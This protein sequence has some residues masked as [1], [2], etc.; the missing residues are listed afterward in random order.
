MVEA[1]AVSMA[2]EAAV[3]TAAAEASMVA[4]DRMAVA[5]AGFV[6]AASTAARVLLAE[7]VVTK[8]AGW[9]RA[10]VQARREIGHRQNG[11]QNGRR[12]FVPPSTMASGILSVTRVVPRVPAQGAVLEARPTTQASPLTTPEVPTDVGIRLAR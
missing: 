1:V 3:F 10:A 6:A 9:E 5:I 8:A 2:V 7:E 12:I 4:A 11:R